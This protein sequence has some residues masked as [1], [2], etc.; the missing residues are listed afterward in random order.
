MIKFIL[1]ISLISGSIC[2]G[3][4]PGRPGPPGPRP[5]CDKTGINLKL[6][7]NL[8]TLSIATLFLIP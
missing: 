6:C 8:D 5:G 7:V 4:R 3:P 1:I 2:G